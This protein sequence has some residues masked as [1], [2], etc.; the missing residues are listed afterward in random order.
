MN[1]YIWT[2]QWA[3]WKNTVAYYK[4]DWN[5]NDS[6]GNSRNLSVGWG[7]V[8]YWTESWGGKYI[9]FNSWAYTNNISMPYKSDGYTINLWG[10]YVSWNKYL[11][12]F[13]PSTSANQWNRFQ[14]LSSTSLYIGRWWGIT[15]PNMSL[16]YNMVIINLNNK[17]NLY[18]NWEYKWYAD[19][20]TRD[21]TAQYFRL[22]SVWYT[23]SSYS[24]YA[25]PNYMS[26]LII[27][28]TA[29]TPEQVAWYYN[30]TKSL[31]WIS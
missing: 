23:V 22:N 10:K 19:L 6:S 9:Y 4:F 26:N 16:W 3:P 15:V 13:Q 18:M 7:T 17:S 2:D 21:T 8:S 12:D 25:W 30:Q 20:W 11:L 29:R 28:N 5:L 31:Y 1:V 27:E 24:N 14:Y